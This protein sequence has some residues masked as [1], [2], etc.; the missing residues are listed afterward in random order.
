MRCMPALTIEYLGCKPIHALRESIEH[1]VHLVA[2]TPLRAFDGIPDD[3]LDVGQHH[4]AMEAREDRQEVVSH[5]L[6]LT[7]PRV[8]RGPAVPGLLFPP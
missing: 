4:L 3:A 7:R 1:R 8:G 6:I 2:K 5:P